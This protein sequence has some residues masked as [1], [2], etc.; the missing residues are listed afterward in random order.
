MKFKIILILGAAV[1]LPLMSCN[2]FTPINLLQ[3][4]THSMIIGIAL[5]SPEKSIDGYAE[6]T[7]NEEIKDCIQTING[8]KVYS[9]KSLVIDGDSPSAWICVYDE[10]GDEIHSIYFYYDIVRYDDE[11]YN[12]DISQYDKLSKLCAKYGECRKE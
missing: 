10:K 6:I 4:E 9:G 7:G 11:E 5:S 8:L 2:R 1:F 12:I 3:E